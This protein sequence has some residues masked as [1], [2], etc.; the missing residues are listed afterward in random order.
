MNVHDEHD[1]MVPY[2]RAVD[3]MQ[4]LPNAY[5]LPTRNLGH[6]KILRNEY[7]LD[8]ILQFIGQRK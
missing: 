4:K 1:D 3:I 2:S 8:E 7:V 6:V 5:H